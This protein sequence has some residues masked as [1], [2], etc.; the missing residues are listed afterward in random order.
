[1]KKLLDVEDAKGYIICM[2]ENISLYRKNTIDDSNELRCE[3][4]IVCMK[5]VRIGHLKYQLEWPIYNTRWNELSI[6]E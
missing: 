6:I 2:S 3:A 5:K 4:W 1:M